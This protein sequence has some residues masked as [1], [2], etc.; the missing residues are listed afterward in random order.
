MLSSGQSANLLSLYS[1]SAPLP[2][3]PYPP[4]SRLEAHNTSTA[5]ATEALVSTFFVCA[6]AQRG[7][8]DF[9]LIGAALGA[10]W[11]WRHWLS[12][13]LRATTF[14]LSML[15]VAREIF[16]IYVILVSTCLKLS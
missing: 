12:Q 6:Q 9:Y 16:V 14:C 3:F 10:L 8:R 15:F 2:A 4:I 11:L 7:K 1:A 5:P 13:H